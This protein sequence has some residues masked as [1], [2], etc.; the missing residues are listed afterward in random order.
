MT[1]PS[2]YG[3]KPQVLML[4]VHLK[5]GGTFLRARSL[6]PV[7]RQQQ[8]GQVVTRLHVEISLTVSSCQ[9]SAFADP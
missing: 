4:R 7:N 9:R 2:H 6:K 1:R 5:L 3:E 8:I